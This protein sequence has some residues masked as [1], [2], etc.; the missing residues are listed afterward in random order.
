[1]TMHEDWTQ[2]IIGVVETLGASFTQPGDDWLPVLLG[3]DQEGQISA[4]DASAAFDNSQT[5]E[6]FATT[7]LPQLI[8]QGTW[9]RVALVASAWIT[10]LSDDERVRYEQGN[11]YVRPSQHPRRKEIII[12]YAC[13][14]G[15]ESTSIAEIRRDKKRPPQLSEWTQQTT[16]DSNAYSIE[17]VWA[18]PI[19]KAVEIVRGTRDD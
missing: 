19:R 14:D 7:I 4:L 6:E 5:K 18:E 10:E 16:K 11:G 17:G 8:I 15:T 3:Q 12:V 1:M 9:H 2:H 13:S